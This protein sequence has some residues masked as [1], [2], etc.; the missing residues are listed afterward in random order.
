M[1]CEKNHFYG[2]DVNGNREN[3]INCN[4][5]SSGSS[6]N[7]LLEDLKRMHMTSARDQYSKLQIRRDG[8]EYVV[9]NEMITFPAM[10]KKN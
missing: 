10:G 7:Q 6:L 8:C 2:R 3:A 9:Y 1:M 5:L 4:L